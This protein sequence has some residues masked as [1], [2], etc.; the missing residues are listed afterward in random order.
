MNALVTQHSK[1]IL[2]L[3]T[4][5]VVLAVVIFCL[6]SPPKTNAQGS[7][8]SYKAI[9]WYASKKTSM[10]IEDG[11]CTIRDKRDAKGDVISREITAN[12]KISGKPLIYRVLTTKK[13]DRYFTWDSDTGKTQPTKYSYH[14]GVNTML[15]TS[16]Y[17]NPP[18]EGQG[19]VAATQ[20]LDLRREDLPSLR[21]TP[22]S[23]NTAK[24]SANPGLGPAFSTTGQNREMKRVTKYHQPLLD[25]MRTVRNLFGHNLV[26][27]QVLSYDPGSTKGFN[28]WLSVD[29]STRE[30]RFLEN[31]ANLMG[32]ALEM[33]GV[34]KGNEMGTWA[35][36]RYGYSY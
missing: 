31:D 18:K 14:H 3:S 24:P 12:I 25:S 9:C 10:Y 21:A 32:G 17:S 27:M 26:Q 4:A 19:F 7:E 1:G 13:G 28:F 30:W 34:I 29:C 8:I 35:C 2:K 22:I 11:A 16:G 6:A 20:A 33:F 5:K 15:S 36:K 23:T